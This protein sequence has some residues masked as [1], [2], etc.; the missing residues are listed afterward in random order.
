MKQIVE[1]KLI[2]DKEHAEDARAEMFVCA[3]RYLDLAHEEFS[4]GSETSYWMGL[5]RDSCMDV[6]SCPRG[7]LPSYI[8]KP[9]IKQLQGKIKEYNIDISM[10][11]TERREEVLA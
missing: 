5:A 10:E 8:L 9:M 6:K 2:V 4:K 7:I 11:L 3:N 1:I